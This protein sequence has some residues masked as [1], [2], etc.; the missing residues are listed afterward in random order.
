MTG[1]GNVTCQIVQ[2]K[3]GSLVKI[4]W[5]GIKDMCHI[6]DRVE[7]VIKPPVL[8]AFLDVS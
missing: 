6:A 7:R 4:S 8:S 3:K 5:S 1:H 2:I